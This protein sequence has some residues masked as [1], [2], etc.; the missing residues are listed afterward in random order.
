MQNKKRTP[1][2]GQN[3]ERHGGEKKI[4][5]SER[6]HEML[7]V[8]LESISAVSVVEVCGNREVNVSGCEG[9]LEYDRERI[10]L[11]VRDGI[12]LLRGREMEMHAFV[13]DRVTVSG[14]IDAVYPV[15]SKLYQENIGE[16]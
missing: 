14:F 7:D 15:K 6:L 3:T 12:V 8:P 16:L 9:V 4:T 2:G 10:L 5:L 1:S 13:Q 11:R